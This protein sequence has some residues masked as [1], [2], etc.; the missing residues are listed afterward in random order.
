[1]AT[2]QEIYEAGFER[3]YNVA[4][5]VDVPEIGSPIDKC[6]DW[7]GYGDV[8]TEENVQDYMETCAF[9]AESNGR[10]YSPFEFTANELNEMED[11]KPYDVWQVFEDG[12]AAGIRKNIAKRMKALA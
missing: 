6:I 1:M 8:V 3:G 7:V 4:S 9:E 11:S 2:K 5:W 10:Q 12:I